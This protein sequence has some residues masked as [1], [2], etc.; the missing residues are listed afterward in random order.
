MAAQAV[1]FKQFAIEIHDIMD[2]KTYIR[3]LQNEFLPRAVH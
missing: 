3:N 2:E 1:R